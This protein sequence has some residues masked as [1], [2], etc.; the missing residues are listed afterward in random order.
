LDRVKFI[1]LT[2][3][4][5]LNL[6]AGAVEKLRLESTPILTSPPDEPETIKFVETI[7]LKPA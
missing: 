5:E 6:S 1:E 3:E 7:S 4:L 2:G